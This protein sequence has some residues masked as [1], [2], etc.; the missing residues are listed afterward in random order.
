[1]SEGG[2]GGY[3]M[4]LWAGLLTII[5]GWNYAS[6]QKKVDKSDLKEFQMDINE[7][8]A[9]MYTLKGRQDEKDNK[10]NHSL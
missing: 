8:K 1:M 2:A 4:E 7:I 6:N 5:S 9:V 10:G 3:F